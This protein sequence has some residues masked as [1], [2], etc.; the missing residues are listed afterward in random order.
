MTPD[1][2]ITPD[3]LFLTWTY[4]TGPTHTRGFPIED[5]Y[6]VFADADELRDMAEQMGIDPDTLPAVATGGTWEPRGIPVS[7]IPSRNG[8]E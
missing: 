4:P 2:N 5:G 7:L 3:R 1:V 8:I 6:A